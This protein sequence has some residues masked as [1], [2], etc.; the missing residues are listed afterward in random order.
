MLT[1]FNASLIGDVSMSNPK[2]K[3]THSAFP[4]PLKAQAKYLRDK[5]LEIHNVKVKSS[6]AHQ[7][8]AGALGFNSK[9]ALLNEYPSDCEHLDFILHHQNYRLDEEKLI[10]SLDSSLKSLPRDFVVTAIEES[11]IPGCENGCGK[12]LDSQP[13][14]DSSDIEQPIAQV[15]D[16]CS[17]NSPQYSYC[18]FCGDS[19]LFRA[20][21][22]NE[23]GE[24]PDHAG[25]SIMD[26]DEETDWET[27]I[28]Y[29]NK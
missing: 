10:D 6:H 24:C 25:E 16:D 29:I 28:E 26:E 20:D 13:L 15:C 14:F 8:L 1:N 19:Y 2:V 23:A 3:A 12:T 4:K 5:V 11:L 7:A 17:D 21:E 22:I 18:R 9:V 27:Y